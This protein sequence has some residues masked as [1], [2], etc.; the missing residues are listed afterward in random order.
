MLGRIS[1]YASRPRIE[2]LNSARNRSKMKPDRPSK[3]LITT[4]PRTASH[5]TTSA[6]WR[7]RSLP[8]TLPMK[9]RSVSSSSSVAPLDPGVALALL[10]ADRQQRDARPVHAQHALGEDRAHARELGEVLGGRVGVGADVE[11]HERPPGR[12]SSGRRGPGA[13]CRAACPGSACRRPCPRPCDPAVT[14]A[15]ASPLLHQ[16]RGDD[17]RAVASCARGRAPGA[18]PSRSARARGRSARWPGSV[19]A[20]DRTTASSPTRITVSSGCARA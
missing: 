5:T 15:S 11:Q 3:N 7:V 13:R 18:R 19:P 20:R 17:D 9:L 8:S 12:R 16:L 14:T 6:I 2:P 1:R 4:L 10:L